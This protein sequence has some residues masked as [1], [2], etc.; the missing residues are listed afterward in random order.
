MD[1]ALRIGILVNDKNE[2]PA[3]EY[4]MLK[5]LMGAEFATI[6]VFIAGR[7]EPQI[8]TS[9][10]YKL[11]RIFEDAWFKSLPDAFEKKNV[12]KEFG[13]I[14]LAA[15]IEAA[16]NYDLDLIYVCHDCLSNN[17]L[18]GIAAYGQWSIEFGTDHYK[19]TR[20][21]AFWE[22][23]NDERVTGA[24]L[25]I[26]LLGVEGFITV[27]KGITPTVPCSVKNNLNSIAWK[28]SSFFHY[29]L[30]ELFLIGSQRFFD[31]YN[32]Q[33]V[34]YNSNSHMTPPSSMLMLWLFVRNVYRYM[35]NKIASKVIRKRFT[36]LYSS[37][38]FSIDHL[39][40]NSFG[41]LPLPDRV[42]YA[43]PFVIQKTERNFVFF[44]EF[45]PE[46]KK[47]HI[48]AMEVYKDGSLSKPQIALEKPYHL[49]YP[50]VFEWEGNYYMV[51]ETSSNRTVE[52]Y[53][54][55]NFP[56]EWEYVMNLMEDRLLIDVTLMFEKGKWWLFGNTHHHDATSTNDQLE[57][58]YNENLFSKEWKA[59]PQNPVA[60]DVSNCRPAGKIFRINNELF[61][62]A[63]NNASQQ[64]GYGLVINK[65]ELMNE[66]EYRE[67]KVTEFLPS[68]KNKLSALHTLN[69]TG[70][71]IFIDG[72]T[73]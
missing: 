32:R 62:P 37:Q 13:S 29:R 4:E 49:S 51:P 61:R 55:K 20:P 23:M 40:L 64:Y 63:Q 28:A 71:L 69:F 46:K 14:P 50:F 54:A 36:L 3:W 22:V 9:F 44:E 18:L 38:K 43:D 70:D 57:L 73:R 35:K 30:R 25:R 56:L 1:T 31:K 59:H 5:G 39:D 6:V 12:L 34:L 68:T 72:I 66:T 41:S 16:R 47:A 15:G 67:K 11:F 24:A 8:K 17:D 33:P 42:F 7:Q 26:K 2:L 48:N 21:P 27:Y 45:S 53:K 19:N 58:Y 52:I 65:I 10:L 60:T